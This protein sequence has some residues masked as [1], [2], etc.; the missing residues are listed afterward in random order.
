M[1]GASTALRI[2]DYIVSRRRHTASDLTPAALDSLQRYLSE[3]F[4]SGADIAVVRARAPL[5]LGLAGGGTDLSPYCDDFGGAVLNV[6][7]SRFAYAFVARRDDDALVFRSSDLGQEERCPAVPRVPTDSGLLLHRGVYNRMIEEFNNGR[8]IG[9]T[10]TTHADVP[11]GS[12]LGTSS[13][14]VVALVDAFRAFLDLPLG[15]YDVARLA[16][17]IERKDL[18][19]PGG[20]QDQYAAAFGGVNFIEFLSNDRAIVN[21]LRVKQSHLDELEASMVTCFTG[22]SHVSEAIVREQSQNMTA[23]SPRA[24]EALHQLKV[25]AQQMKHALLTG[26]IEEL[27]SILERSWMAKKATAKD[28][29][30]PLIEDLY[31][32]AMRNG[33]LAGKVSGAGGGGFMMFVVPPEARPRL[34]N[35]LRAHGGNAE[36]VHFTPLGCETWIRWR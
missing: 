4:Q 19:L 27:A 30:N 1:S 33:A 9:L 29:S 24:I 23:H 34:V 26:D 2:T 16:Y 35:A 15:R 17:E 10:V 12:G 36:A 22:Q 3:Y 20:K 11:A 25:D 18:K 8:P 5:R 6:T 31:A 32:C 28:I 21:P 13:A 7:I 14:I